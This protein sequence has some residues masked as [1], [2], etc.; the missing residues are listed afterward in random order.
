MTLIKTVFARTKFPWYR[1]E[2]TL[3]PACFPSDFIANVDSK[4]ST[5]PKKNL[6]FV[7]FMVVED[8]NYCCFLRENYLHTQTL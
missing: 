7:R 6:A 2:R 5:W 4:P 3:R 1:K 8:T